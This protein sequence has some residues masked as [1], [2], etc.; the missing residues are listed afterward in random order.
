MNFK[1]IVSV[2]TSAA[3]LGSTIAL[4]A[5]AS[6]PQPFVKNGMADVAVVY[7]SSAAGT[8]FLA[9][10]DI[11]KQ[12]TNQLLKEAIV[13]PGSSGSAVTT[14]GGDSVNLASSS[15]RL[16]M[17]SSINVAKTT[18]ASQDLPNLLA[19]GIASDQNG[20]QYKYQ[21]KFTVNPT[22]VGFTKSGESIDPIPVLDVGS[23]KTNGL[24]N[25]TLTFTKVLNV[26]DTTNVAGVSNIKILG[27]EYIVGANSDSNTLYLYGSGQ[28]TSADE[29]ETKTVTIGDKEHTV[30]LK[31]STSATAATVIIDGVQ[32]SVTKGN[33]YK[34]P[35][36]FEVYVKDVYHTTK[37]GALSN[38]VLLVGARSLHFEDGQD[39]R[40]GTDDTVITGTFANVS[41]TAGQGITSLTVSQTFADATGD[42]VKVGGAFTDRVFDGAYKVTFASLSPALDDKS[43][44]KVLFDSDNS[45]ST[46]VTFTY[47]VTDKTGEYKEKTFSYGRNPAGAAASTLA[48]TNLAGENNYSISVLEGENLS[49]NSYVIVNSGDKGRILQLVDLPSATGANDET[50]FRD[51]LT[52]DDFKFV[53]GMTSNGSSL[54]I[55]GQPYYVMSTG[56][57]GSANITWGSASSAGHWGSA[58]TLFPR[59]KLRNGGWFAILANTNI[60]NST[61]TYSIP[62][63]DSLTTYETGTQFSWGNNTVNTTTVGKVNYNI[64][65]SGIATGPA[66]ASGIISNLSLSGVT[67]NFNASTGPAI[68]IQEPKTATGQGSTNGEVHCISLTTVGSTTIKPAISTTVASSESS[69]LLASR[70]LQTTSTKSTGVSIFGTFIETNAPDSNI[71]TVALWLPKEQMYTDVLVTSPATTVS[72]GTTGNTTSSGGATTVGNVFALADS[73]IT[74]VSSK[75]LIVVGGSCI[76]TVAAKLLGS[77]KPLCG[78]DFQTKTGAGAGSYVLQTF[79]SPYTTGKVATLVAGYNAAD[80]TNGVKFLTTQANVDVS[81]GKKYLNGVAA[82]T[83]VT[84]TTN[85]TTKK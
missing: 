42:Y 9:A 48:R 50:V 60:T 80:T 74:T 34:F 44:E 28:S 6:Y 58:R 3:M 20:V 8:D 85:D 61:Y 23:T 57:D 84:L 24:L 52:S 15:Q 70:N 72:G 30:S 32:K 25:Y 67:C 76:N 82:E 51:V 31:G 65:W 55:D 62:G 78:S 14:S 56:N 12:L 77:D 1:K 79:A 47:P 10:L 69:N 64:N 53:T 38:I 46:R 16:F 81:A 29:G 45:I 49:L 71:N 41:G 33:S 39:V 17:N 63:V 26:S 37:T 27:K 7:G 22:Q 59:I 40:Y 21:Q 83:A 54:N 73:E 2:L 18:L 4:A 75:N 19:D 5:A 68:L 36:D 66:A 35:G 11:H 43:R 13:T